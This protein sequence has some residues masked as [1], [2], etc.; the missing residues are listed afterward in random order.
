M[1]EKDFFRKYLSRLKTLK[2]KT[3]EIF[4]RTKS[5]IEK[6]VKSRQISEYIKNKPRTI[7]ATF[8]IISIFAM[9]FTGYKVNEI[10]TRAFEV[11]LD[12]DNIGAVRDEESALMILKELEANLSKEYN[13]KIVVDKEIR[14]EPSHV[15]DSGIL[16]KAK[17]EEAIQTKLNFL[18]SG[19]SIIVNGEEVGSLKT[20]KDANDVVNTVKGFYLGHLSE[21]SKLID[22]NILEDIEYIQKDI[23]LNEIA[24]K[25]DVIE[26][27]KEGSEEV[28]THLVEVGESFWTIAKIYN[29]TTDELVEANPDKDPQKLKPGDEVR[30]LVPKSKITV[31][32]IEE[33][34][35]VESTNYDVKVELSSSMY[36]NQQKTKVEGKK[37][38]IK[39]LANEVKHNG[40]LV[41]KKIL[42]EKLVKDPVTQVVVKGTK[43]IPRTVATGAFLMPTRGR[44]SSRYGMRWGRMHKGIDIAAPSGTAIKA[45]DGGSVVFAG[46]KGSYGY[47]VEVNHGNG[48]RTRYAH[49]SKLHVK[50]GQKVYKG[51]H[52]ANVGNT[53]NSTGPHLHFEVLRNGKNQNPSSFVR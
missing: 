23:P 10:K 18:V 26:H 6:I 39:V 35:Y 16:T 34:E 42:D 36:K 15:K 5:K 41:D 51:Q 47:M 8:M 43:E 13:A 2:N 17:L 20:K 48:Y 40:V 28:R 50:V 38:E 45:A 31:E 9:G 4:K 49:C 14:F 44:I 52:I 32:T 24:Q 19:Y 22:V 7:L 37:G 27:I 46:Y 25:E 3:Y 1:E 21:D 29:T 12:Q 11:Y 53:G 33:V 30:L